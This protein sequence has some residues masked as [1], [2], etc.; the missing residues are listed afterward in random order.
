MLRKAA[1]SAHALVSC[2]KLSILRQLSWWIDSLTAPAMN[3]VITSLISYRCPGAAGE[4]CGYNMEK[5]HERRRYPANNC[6]PL[7]LRRYSINASCVRNVLGKL[8][9]AAPA[10]TME[11]KA[12]S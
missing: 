6:S 9:R 7:L 5:K 1:K 11:Q 4:L 12:F 10:A 8:I 3:F 2:G